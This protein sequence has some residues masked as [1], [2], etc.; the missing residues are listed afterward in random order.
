MAKAKVEAYQAAIC[1]IRGTIGQRRPWQ[2]VAE[3]RSPRVSGGK[4]GGATYTAS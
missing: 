4:T 2:D 1:N 3:A